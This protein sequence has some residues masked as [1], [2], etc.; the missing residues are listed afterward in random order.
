[1]LLITVLLHN[2]TVFMVGPV[3]MDERTPSEYSNREQ[4]SCFHQQTGHEA[5]E[6][7]HTTTTTLFDSW[8]DAFIVEQTLN[9]KCETRLCVLCGQQWFV[10]GTTILFVPSVFFY[11][12]KM[13]KLGDRSQTFQTFDFL[14]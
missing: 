9:V 11:A 10:P 12:G 3:L 4:I 8:Y 14:D 1:M 6:D 13:K 2:P 7:H 5:A